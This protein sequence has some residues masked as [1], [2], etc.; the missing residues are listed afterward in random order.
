MKGFN[1]VAAGSGKRRERGQRETW[2]TK[3]VRSW[4]TRCR[5]GDTGRGNT[6]QRGALTIQCVSFAAGIASI[7]FVFMRLVDRVDQR[8]LFGAGAL[9]QVA[10]MLLLSLLRLTEPVALGYVLLA[11]L[12]GGFGQQSF[13]QLWSGELFPTLL[14]ST[15]QGL[16]FAV[17]R[18]ALGF[19]SLYVPTLTKSGFSTLAWILTGFVAVSGL[20]G[21]VFAPRNQ[22]KTL[23]QIQRERQLQGV[24]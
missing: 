8:L 7:Y 15:A 12:G 6:G 3:E 23:D 22:G 20:I 24:G 18:I 11:G 10:G 4:S 17:V 9:L 5:A 1:F 14:R 21:F 13:F 16:M 2:P 19:W